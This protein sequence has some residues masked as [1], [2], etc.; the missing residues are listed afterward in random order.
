MRFELMLCLVGMNAGIGFLEFRPS[1]I[2]A[3]VA[4]SVSGEM[5]TL[6]IDKAISSFI[7]VEKGRVLKCVEL[8]KN[9]SLINGSATANAN[10]ATPSAYSVAQSLI[11]VLDAACL[12]Y[13]SDEITVGSCANSSPYSPDIKRKKQNKPS[14]LDF[15][16]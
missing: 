2:A 16:S 8:M 15:K 9:L 3:A 1:E 11:G 13:K 6:A 4:I 10:V 5:Q 7:F 12:S 14:Q